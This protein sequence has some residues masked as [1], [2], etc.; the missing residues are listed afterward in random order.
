MRQCFILLL[1]KLAVVATHGQTSLVSK[2]IIP[3]KP[4]IDSAAMNAWPRIGLRAI[5]DDGNYFLS[6][7]E[8]QPAGMNKLEVIALHGSWNRQ[9]ITTERPDAFFSKDNRQLVLKLRDTLLFWD[10]GSSSQKKMRIKSFECPS[11]RWLS[12]T[13]MDNPNKLAIFDL[14]TGS[15]QLYENI[16]SYWF[17]PTGSKLLLLE[18]WG[19]G[20]TGKRLRYVEFEKQKE[21]IIWSTKASAAQVVSNSVKFDKNGSQLA[22]FFE[23]KKGN[24]SLRIETSKAI[25]FY[26]LGM[27]EAVKWMNL[28]TLDIKRKFVIPHTI[29]FSENANWIIFD[30]KQEPLT[31]IQAIKPLPNAVKLSIWSYKDK[32]LQPEQRRLLEGGETIRSTVAVSTQTGKMIEIVENDQNRQII[33][34]FSDCVVV[35]DDLDIPDKGNRSSQFAYSVVSLSDGL[36]RPLKKEARSLLNFSNSPDGKWLVFYD[37]KQ[38]AY[39]SFDTETGDIRNI[40]KNVPANFISDGDGSV[41]KEPVA[42]VAGWLSNGQGLVLYDAYDIWQIDPAGKRKPVNITNGLGKKLRLKLRLV[43]GAESTMPKDVFSLG[44]SVLITAFSPDNKYNGFYRKKIGEIGDPEKLYLGPYIFYRTR[45][46]KAHSFGEPGMQPVKALTSNVWIVRRQSAIEFP[47]YYVTEDFKTYKALTNLQPQ[48]KFN[49]L[50]AELITWRQLDGTMSQGVLYKPENFDPSK[51]YP[52]LFNYYEKSSH[53]LYEFLEPTFSNDNID[54]PWFVSRGYLVFT[55]DIH[56]SIASQSGKTAGECAYN[57]VVSAAQYLAKLSYVDPKRMGLQGH[58]FG[59]FQTAYI[60]THTNLF[61][62]A[63]EAAGTTDPISSYLTLIPFGAS[64]EHMPKQSGAESGQGRFGATLWQRPD[65]YIRS[66]SVLSADKVTTP[67]LIMHN[68]RDG[69]VPWRQGVEFYMALRRLHKPS[70]MLQYDNGYHSVDGEDAVDYTIRMTQFFDHYLKGA[71][72]PKWMTE[73]VPYK[74]RGIE[75]GFEL[76]TSGKKP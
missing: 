13:L 36:W 16:I 47:N 3:G 48:K 12:Y 14:F 59:G 64:F 19:D 5:S 9:I 26:K 60:V 41:F 65:L 50:S 27:R 33:D 1:F 74:L 73:G 37:L 11:R 71:L 53:R 7:I 42:A 61:A 6:V 34:F 24:D 63:V 38:L 69:N 49:W 43:D 67:I 8:N 2:E 70:W 58:S 25:W 28:D 4:I 15:E 32:K 46:Q 18:Q 57:S 21:F 17:D 22:F 44:E 75:T 76:D 30:L 56:Y 66:S 51:K 40:T 54:I 52:V 10:L 35:M 45:S 31:D 72:P 23:E 68:E 39:F 55:P 62:A 29:R 20:A